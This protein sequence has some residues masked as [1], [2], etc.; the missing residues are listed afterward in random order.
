MLTECVCSDVEEDGWLV[1][2]LHFLDTE[3]WS[4]DLI[5][6]PWQVSDGWSL[7]DSTELVV[8]GTVA[9]AD[10]TLVGTQVGNGDAAQ[11]CANGGSADD[12]RVA[13]V[14]DGCLRFLVELRGRW[15]SIGL[16][17]FGLGQTAHEDEITIP[18]GLEDLTRGQLRNVELLVCVTNVSVT[19]DH[20]IV[21]DGD[22]GF[23]AQDVVAENEALDHVHLCTTD[24]VVAVLFVPNSRQKKGKIL[25]RQSEFGRVSSI[26]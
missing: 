13:G 9:K 25:E 7:S 1:G 3:D 12:T 2:V 6:D 11:M 15:Q 26:K 19:G 18:G 8:D 23:D 14:G 4:M 16:I 10:P 22:E 24:F 20:L 17:D 5:V 21:N